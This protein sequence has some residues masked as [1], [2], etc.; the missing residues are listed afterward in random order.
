MKNML[1]NKNSISSIGLG[2]YKGS[3]DSSDDILQFNSII[4]SVL[5]G[6]NFIDTCS[7]FRGG[8]S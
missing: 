8:R 4:D 2:T 3:L 7:N 6:V 5:S 1:S